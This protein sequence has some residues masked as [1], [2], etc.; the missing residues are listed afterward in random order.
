MTTDPLPVEQDDR[1][2]AEFAAKDIY[3]ANSH[4]L[5]EADQAEIAGILTQAFARH[6]LATRPQH[7]REAIARLEC[8]FCAGT[9]IRFNNHG[10]KERKFGD[11]HTDAMH[12]GDT[13]WSTCCYQCGATFPNMYSREKLE[14]KWRQRPA[15]RAQPDREAIARLAER[16]WRVHP[17]ELQDAGI[18]R[19][20]FYE[21]EMLA[22]IASG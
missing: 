11:T 1:D 22:L 9:D 8:P 15:T 16:F 6:R 20:Q 12:Y 14:E 10:R 5:C 3:F 7:D 17:K 2:A 18:T 21:R 4:T 13:I 19:Q